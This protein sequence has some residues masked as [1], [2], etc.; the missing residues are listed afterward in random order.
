[1]END[2]LAGMEEEDIKGQGLQ[3]WVR[4]GTEGGRG[5]LEIGSG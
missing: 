2:G 4:K 3:G 1:M 5:W